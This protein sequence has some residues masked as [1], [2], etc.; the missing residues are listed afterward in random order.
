MEIRPRINRWTHSRRN[1][2]FGQSIAESLVQPHF[3]V[4][5]KGVNEQIHG[6]PGINRQSSD[7]L[8]KQISDD[9]SIGITSHMI[10]GV[11][12]DH[13]KDENGTSAA[14]DQM[15]LQQ[16]VRKLKEKFGDQIVVMTDSCL[17]T[18]TDHGHCGLV[19]DGV[20]VNDESVDM[21]VK[22]S[23]SHANSGADYVCLSDMM[24]GRVRS[25]RRA[26]EEKGMRSTGVLSYSVK[27]ASSFYGPFR[28]AA[29]SAPTFGDRSSHQ[30]DP[31]SDY[32]EAIL[33]AELDV[34]EGSDILMI[35]PGL[36]YLD[37]LREVSSKVNRPVAVYN[38]S[39]EYSMVMDHATDVENRHKMVVEILGSFKRAG[40]DIIV[41]YHTREAIGRGWV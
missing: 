38:V 18:S 6:M 19:Q 4:S 25:V 26:F 13:H 9:L 3:V 31:R 37:V 12:E 11:L 30:M 41:S 17:C 35:K 14:D 22:I 7:V 24:D 20:I 27:Y 16:T 15:P 33:E 36:P 10:F 34:Q 28:S 2:V 21:L 39:G 1:L 23:L 5:G 29:S 40:A 8:I 32:K